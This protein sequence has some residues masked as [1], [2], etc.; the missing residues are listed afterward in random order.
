MLRKTFI[1]VAALLVSYLIS[2]RGP[3][4]PKTMM[5]SSVSWRTTR[6]SL[7]R[8]GHTL[9]QACRSRLT[10]LLTADPP[11]GRSWDLISEDIGTVGEGQAA[12]KCLERHSANI[13]VSPAHGYRPY[14]SWLQ[15]WLEENDSPL[16]PTVHGGTIPGNLGGT[17]S[18]PIFRA[19]GLDEAL[20]MS[21]SLYADSVGAKTAVIFAT[22]VEGFQLAA[23]AAALA[24]EAIGIKV[25][26]TY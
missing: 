24:A 26:A 9:R 13:L 12:R 5:W 14:R 22:Q 17:G 15:E 18:E 11:L 7:G 8:T 23:S 1:K 19:Q 6:V 4:K 21:G 2:D 3:W 25:L 20:G 16:M 10:T